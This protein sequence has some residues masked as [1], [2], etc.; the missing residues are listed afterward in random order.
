VGAVA[1]QVTDRRDGAGV[2]GIWVSDGRDWARSDQRGRY[3]LTVHAPNVWVRCP[4]GWRSDRWWQPAA[5]ICDFQLEPTPPRELWRLAHLSDPHVT[6]GD[7]SGEEH[8]A[9]GTAGT[10]RETA[11]RQ[12]VQRAHTRGAHAALVTGDLT[13]LGTRAELRRFAHICDT[14]PLP[15]HVVPGN[16]DHY[17]HLHESEPTDDPVGSG[18]LGSA[19]VTRYEQIMGPRWWSLTLDGLHIIGL[20]WFSMHRGI[21][22][23]DQVRFVGDDLARL[24]AG[25]NVLVIAHDQVPTAVTDQIDAAA[26]HVRLVGTLSGHWHAPKVTLAQ[27]VAHVSTGP[28]SFGGLDWTPP[29]LRM[30]TWDGGDL[31]VGPPEPVRPRPT[32]PTPPSRG[33]TSIRLGARQHLGNVRALDD[34]VLTAT[35]DDAGRS[36]VTAVDVTGTVRWRQVVADAYPTGIAHHGATAVVLTCSGTAHAFATDDGT[37]RWTHRLAAPRRRRSIAAPVI[38]DRDTVVFG[39]V[40][41]I[42]AVTLDT[43]ALLWERRDPALLDTLLTYGT[44]SAVDGHVLL[45]FGGP[46]RGLTCLDT[47]DGATVWEDD[48]STPPPHSS[49]LRLGDSDALV[50]RAGPLL[51]RFS[52]ATGRAVWRRDLPEGFATAT[53]AAR[54]GHATAVTGDGVALHVRLDDGHIVAQTRLRSRRPGWGPYRVGGVGAP[55]GP[56]VCGER[57]VIVLIDGTVTDLT[58]VAAPRIIA[59]V[60]AAVTTQPAAWKGTLAVVDTTGWLHLVDLA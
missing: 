49:I 15:L 33:R 13:D 27:G 7:R 54:G 18:F 50:L 9:R 42:A 32:L 3:E 40:G 12:A 53:P 46:T 20:D 26:G 4:A 14:S 51:E 5:A 30:L 2:P 52:V 34:A 16:H 48:G 57:T 41:H 35:E 1:G 22:A 45:P 21:D 56:V 58:D 6:R 43:G 19:T 37:P 8:T 28:T 47:S 24:P 10:D 36:V 60:G 31:Q 25:S 11:F 44:G 39:D 55:T 38:V 17:G 59:D 29:H 23:D